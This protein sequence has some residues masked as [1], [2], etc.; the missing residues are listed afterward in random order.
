MHVDP[1]LYAS[2]VVDVGG[3]GCDFVVEDAVGAGG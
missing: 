1:E 2:D 3:A